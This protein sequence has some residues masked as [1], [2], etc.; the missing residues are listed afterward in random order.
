LAVITETGTRRFF[1]VSSFDR[2][3]EFAGLTRNPATPV[4]GIIP[5][6]AVGRARSILELSAP[7]SLCARASEMRVGGRYDEVCT[8]R[9]ERAWS[10]QSDAAAMLPADGTTGQLT[11]GRAP[12]PPPP[13]PVCVPPA[14]APP[15]RPGWRGAAAGKTALAAAAGQRERRRPGWLLLVSGRA[16]GFHVFVFYDRSAGARRGAEYRRT[17][18]I[19]INT[20]VL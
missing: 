13:H 9:H 2:S 20:A 17:R 6:N 4:L 5:L 19:V 10:V 7:P 16:T 14:R 8:D 1:A 3:P 12:P 11:A 18:N 15:R